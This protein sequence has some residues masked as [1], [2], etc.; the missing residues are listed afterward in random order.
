MKRALIIGLC[1]I[2]VKGYA[3]LVQLNKEPRGC[4]PLPDISSSDSPMVSLTSKVQKYP[5]KFVKAKSIM[6]ILILLTFPSYVYF[7]TPNAPIMA[8]AFPDAVLS[9]RQVDLNL[10]GNSSVGRTNVVLLGPK[11]AKKNFSPYNAAKIHLLFSVF[12]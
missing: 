11:L 7:C 4:H 6:A 12:K 9:A 3:N 5:T 10:V 8:P 2:G 1:D